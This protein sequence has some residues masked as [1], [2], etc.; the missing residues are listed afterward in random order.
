MHFPQL[1]QQTNIATTLTCITKTKQKKSEIIGECTHSSDPPLEAFDYR[2]YNADLRAK[3]DR[4][5]PI[6]TVAPARDGLEG[7]NRS[8]EIQR[9]V[10]GESRREKEIIKK[11]EISLHF[12]TV[13]CKSVTCIFTCYCSIV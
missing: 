13:T 3:T 4:K 8:G 12:C 2:S 11:A 7:S 5:S 10:T 9:S 6:D 1:S